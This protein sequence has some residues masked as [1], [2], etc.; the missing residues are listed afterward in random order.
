MAKIP[1]ITP[2]RKRN[3]RPLKRVSDL[4]RFLERG[5][6][7]V[8]FTIFRGQREAWPLLPKIARLRLMGGTEPEVEMTMLST[9]QREA[10]SFLGHNPADLWEWLA[11]AQH[12]T[13]PT[14]LLDWTKNPLAALWFA[15]RKPAS[16]ADRPAVL[17]IFQPSWEDVMEPAGI[18]ETPF[19]NMRMRVFEPR[20]V[21]PRIRAQ[22]GVFTVHKRTVEH[23][24]FAPL[25]EHPECKEQLTKLTIPPERFATI[26]LELNDCGIHAGSLF[27]DLDGLSQQIESEFTAPCDMSII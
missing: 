19:D 6:G 7:D 5:S 10:S 17:W 3:A 4:L 24:D 9:F 13:L 25:D 18:E 14:R 12:H 27:P 16:K 20:H 11:I 23:G 1:W 26:R 8:H 2:G 22:E 21:I 15:V